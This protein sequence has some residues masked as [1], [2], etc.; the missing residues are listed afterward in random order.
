MNELDGA[1]DSPVRSSV[2]GS[3]LSRFN[4]A[5]LSSAFSDGDEKENMVKNAD[6]S[7]DWAGIVRAA[8]IAKVR[9]MTRAPSVDRQATGLITDE[10]RLRTFFDIIVDRQHVSHFTSLARAYLVGQ[11]LEDG[12]IYDAGKAKLA[13]AIVALIAAGIGEGTVTLVGKKIDDLA[14]LNDDHLVS[15]NIARRAVEIA[16]KKGVDLTRHI[17]VGLEEKFKLNKSEIYKRL[18]EYIGC[19]N[20][21]IRYHIF[22]GQ[23]KLGVVRSVD[24]LLAISDILVNRA[25]KISVREAGEML[26]KIISHFTEDIIQHGGAEEK[27]TGKLKEN[28]LI[29]LATATQEHARRLAPILIRQWGISIDLANKIIDYTPTLRDMEL[30]TPFIE[31]YSREDVDS[32]GLEILFEEDYLSLDA[33]VKLINDDIIKH[34]DDHGASALRTRVGEVLLKVLSVSEILEMPLVRLNLLE[35]IFVTT[36]LEK[37]SIDN[38]QPSAGEHINALAK[39]KN[40]DD[41]GPAIPDFWEHVILTAGS[42]IVTAW[43]L[44][45][46][47]IYLILE[48]RTRGLP[49]YLKNYAAELVQL[50]SR[51]RIYNDEYSKPLYGDRR[52]HDAL[53]EVLGRA[54]YDLKN[55]SSWQDPAVIAYLF[56]LA[57]QPKENT[58]GSR[59][60]SYMIARVYNK[61]APDMVD[62]EVI[63]D[64]LIQYNNID[65]DGAWII[66]A[67]HEDVLRLNGWILHM[68]A[69]CR[70]IPQQVS[71]GL[72]M[73]FRRLH[74]VDL[75][76]PIAALRKGADNDDA[77]W[78]VIISGD[79]IEEDGSAIGVDAGGPRR[80]YYE[81]LGKRLGEKFFKTSEEGYA[82]P[83]EDL[84]ADD[85]KIIGLAL[86]RSILIEGLPLGLR[87]HPYVCV[88]LVWPWML[89]SGNLDGVYPF[90]AIRALCND[91]RDTKG[92]P[93]S[94]WISILAPT[95]KSLFDNPNKKQIF[96]NWKWTFATDFTGK[97]G[98]DLLQYQD[99]RTFAESHCDDYT[100]PYLDLPT[101]AKG[102]SYPELFQKQAV[103]LDHM[104]GVLF[105]F[106]ARNRF[107][108]M[109]SSINGIASG[110]GISRYL[111]FYKNGFSNHIIP[112]RNLYNIV[113]GVSKYNL[114]DLGN[115]IDID[116]N[117]MNEKEK[118]QYK[119]A[120]MAALKRLDADE[121]KRVVTFWS[122]SS[123]L[124]SNGWRDK[125]GNPARVKIIQQDWSHVPDNKIGRL[126]AAHTCFF[127][128]DLPR[129]RESSEANLDK[130]ADKLLGLLKV[131]SSG[132]S[133]DVCA[134]T[135][136]GG[137]TTC[138]RNQRRKR[139]GLSIIK[140]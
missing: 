126:I 31:A 35:P 127:Q 28:L 82:V 139:L 111:S 72:R 121:L 5:A 68:V 113:Q 120:F 131:I 94:D 122:G 96:H 7:I 17:V 81:A 107:S 53:V 124:T 18:T 91:L 130:L 114:E 50:F 34:L 132:I 84:P 93:D 102:H 97:C 4:Q 16:N 10:I 100:E 110:F 135:Q 33:L 11:K 74:K 2:S 44:I 60:D 43:K 61:M 29:I 67:A 88:C 83:V 75:K 52:I 138:H 32:S 99:I 87:I 73:D 27:T 22:N 41:S 95:A 115:I 98:D 59:L 21:P 25:D 140:H 8:T 108:A 47:L 90:S 20:I 14:D 38:S 64:T 63:C 24:D 86:R 40:A 89:E 12:K 23:Y 133:V 36:L 71:E 45:S 3:L 134:Y 109:I 116:A 39:L 48:S 125:I 129:Q 1:A 136:N 128:L 57:A 49:K 77:P 37:I 92:D 137:C 62:F 117:A 51:C 55:G 119:T 65:V 54:I 66:P 42:N 104:L 80:D 9:N 101:E 46:N 58:E 103:Q 56:S 76:D 19:D 106:E 30:L 112:P 6:H 105:R 85:L 70:T 26:D 79:G 15:A 13:D 69:S 78:A 118:V 123:I